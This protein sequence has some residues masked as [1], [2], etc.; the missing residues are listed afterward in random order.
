M[1]KSSDKSDNKKDDKKYRKKKE[2]SSDD[3]SD[4]EHDDD[5]MDKKEFKKFLNK[6]FPSKY[7]DEEIK[8]DKKDKKGKKHKTNKRQESESESESEDSEEE[9]N[10]G[11]IVK[12]KKYKGEKLPKNMKNINLVFTIDPKK[13][14]VTEYYD[15]E[16]DEDDDDDYD[17][18]YDD[19]DD[20]ESY[21]TESDSEEYSDDEDESDSENDEHEDEDDDEDDDE[22]YEESDK[23][24][25]TEDKEENQKLK[26]ELDQKK[27]NLLNDE[28]INEK[29]HLTELENLYK[30]NKSS[31]IKK[32]IKVCKEELKIKE[33]KVNKKIKKMQ[34]KNT[35][36]FRKHLRN[37]NK[38]NDH[39]YFQ[40]LPIDHQRKLL[41][42]VKEI[43]NL[44]ED[45]KPYRISLLEADIPPHFKA[46]AFKKINS[47]RHMEPGGGEYY[48]MK[49]WIDTFMKIPFNKY[50]HL[51]V[52]AEDGVEKCH[53]FME[54]AKNILDSAVYGLND[55][56]M[57]IMQLLGQLLTNPTATGTTIAIQGP[58]GTGKTTMVK[59]G[60]SKILQRDFAFIALGGA[61]DS[62]Y[63][64]GHSYTYEGSTWGQIVNILV[65][66]QSMNPVIY[67]DELDK[68]SDTPKG[69]EI[70]GILTH[71]TD[72]S[73]NSQFNDKYFSE[74]DFDLSKCLF[75]FSYNDITKI[76]PI[77]RDRMYT[78]QT[79]G[80][81]QKEKNIISRNHILPFIREQV[82]FKEEDIIISDDVI[83]YIIETHTG[84]EEGM[85]NL[86]RCLEIIYSK[87]NL[88][89]LMKPDTNLFEQ[90]MSI[91]V[92][93]P[94]EVTKEIVDKLIK[95]KENSVSMNMM[96]M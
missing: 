64:E 56:K 37:K 71:L 39:I 62:S 51:P 95:K 8:K 14:N 57:Q 28:I 72:T 46:C 2:I 16:D 67:F 82:K 69:E 42:E 47:L 12:G 63:L 73:Q 68:V 76:N 41:N 96:Y 92:Q 53:D 44:V 83:K 77:L 87:L 89:R 80:Y 93:F 54:N 25:D 19:D 90:D 78:I 31:V 81:N 84:T 91:Q 74:I 88:Y 10:K 85:R 22:E 1:A 75:I 27:T 32:A 34:D 29:R 60:I 59:E 5:I 65:K 24:S 3:E 48:K 20:D 33:K 50:K 40:K 45:E 52:T 58:M 13:K 26:E 17:D 9:K 79:K 6:I 21:E 11:L 66:S 70:I 61:T 7:L 43:N 23:T 18:Y 4:I 36:N 49:N 38:L 94:F 15:D 86:K 35:K 30:E 55:A